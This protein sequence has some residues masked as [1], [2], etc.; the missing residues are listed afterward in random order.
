MSGPTSGCACFH[1]F[2]NGAAES[3]QSL[4]DDSS[5]G[6]I[7]GQKSP[8]AKSEQRRT[9]AAQLALGDPRAGRGTPTR[10]AASTCF[11]LPV[12]RALVLQSLLQA[13]DSIA[14]KEME[15]EP[16]PTQGETLTQWGGE[17]VKII[18]IEKAKDIPLVTATRSGLLIE[19]AP[20]WL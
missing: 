19:G 4:W 17:T 15:P 2:C 5:H 7:T 3:S 11:Y 14:E 6:M 9:G 1:G 10:P 18:R 13:H 16:L 12:V 20:S 8:P